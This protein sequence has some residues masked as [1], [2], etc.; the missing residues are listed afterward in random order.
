MATQTIREI[1]LKGLGDKA[2][3]ETDLNANKLILQERFRLGNGY[4]KKEQEE[5]YILTEINNFQNC[6]LINYVNARIEEGPD[7]EFEITLPE[8]NEI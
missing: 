1:T 8:I 5:N 7:D 2:L 4:C 6:E 3:K